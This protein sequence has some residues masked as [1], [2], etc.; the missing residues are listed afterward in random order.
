M[1]LGTPRAPNHRNPPGNGPNERVV[2][3]PKGCSGLQGLLQTSVH[4]DP[5][6]ALRAARALSRWRKGRYRGRTTRRRPQHDQNPSYT[7][8]ATMETSEIEWHENRG[9]PRDPSNPLSV[10]KGSKFHEATKNC[11]NWRDA[12]E[13]QEAR[14]TVPGVRVEQLVRKVPVPDPT[15]LEGVKFMVKCLGA[16][17][18]LE[19]AI[20]LFISEGLF[21]TVDDNGEGYADDGRE[22]WD[23]EDQ[24]Y[25]SDSEAEDIHRK[26]RPSKAGKPDSDSP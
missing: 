14:M 12:R 16:A 4:R 19:G 6:A 10:P 22:D 9:H 13:D 21:D 17:E 20:D 8:N 24:R 2:S 26:G 18:Y 23:R 11:F 25:D 5:S 15:V 7:A 1:G 3:I